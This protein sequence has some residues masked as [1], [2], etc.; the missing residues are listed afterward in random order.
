MSQVISTEEQLTTQWLQKTDL[1]L[2]YTHTY[3][4]VPL[5]YRQNEFTWS[6]A[7]RLHSS[8]YVAKRVY[9]LSNHDASTWRRQMFVSLDPQ[10]SSQTE[11][12]FRRVQV[13][14]LNL[15]HCYAQY[16]S[17]LIYSRYLNLIECGRFMKLTG[18]E[19]ADD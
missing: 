16:Y 6:F 12:F 11:Y 3:I 15:L 5:A 18:S 1:Y 4:V 17:F 9:L 7:L 19:S 2:P 10:K 14:L 8:P 13:Q